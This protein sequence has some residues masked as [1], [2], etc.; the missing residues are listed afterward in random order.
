MSPTLRPKATRLRV[1]LRIDQKAFLQHCVSSKLYSTETDA[2]WAAV[3]FLRIIRQNYP[4]AF[5]IEFTHRNDNMKTRVLLPLASTSLL[6]S[7]R[8]AYTHDINFRNVPPDVKYDLEWI[9]GNEKV[10]PQS[11]AIRAAIELLS[12]VAPYLNGDWLLSALEMNGDSV[13][14]PV[15]LYGGRSMSKSSGDATSDPT[16]VETSHITEIIRKLTECALSSTADRLTLTT[17]EMNLLLVEEPL[18]KDFL[19]RPF[20]DLLNALLTKG[21]GRI[22]Q[23]L[24][25]AMASAVA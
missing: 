19:N 10:D 15:D 22:S 20:G 13:L 7:G 4:A 5:A 1:R 9:G 23:S 18:V 11:A 2:V 14:I 6:V 17:D 21:S 8:G 24:N 12:L 16:R 25:A 3:R